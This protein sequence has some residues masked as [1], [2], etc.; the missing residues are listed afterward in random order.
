MWT[1][2]LAIE[3]W[4]SVVRAMYI[5]LERATAHG[6]ILTCCSTFQVCGRRVKNIPRIYFG[7]REREK[8]LRVQ[9]LQI[10][11]STVAESVVELLTEISARYAE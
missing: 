6:G 10:L 2:L 7:V 5:L 11:V 8:R 9:N 4:F 1:E 3:E